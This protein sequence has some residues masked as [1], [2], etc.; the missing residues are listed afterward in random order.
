M[1]PSRRDRT[2][3]SLVGRYDC[4]PICFLRAVEAVGLAP[5]G[6]GGKW[7]ERMYAVRRPFFGLAVSG[8]LGRL[9]RPF[10]SHA[11]WRIS[12]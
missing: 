4:F 7:I 8:R 6:E 1:G 2:G 3:W 10:H 9:A 11:V 12:V 5:K